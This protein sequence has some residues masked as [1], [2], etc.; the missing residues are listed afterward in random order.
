MSARR[1]ELS[2]KD[3]LVLVADAWG[4]PGDR[5]VLL[6]HGGGQTRH[7]WGGTA[8]RLAKAGWYAVALDLRGHGDSAWDPNADYG[9]D[10]Y[11]ADTLEVL[12]QLGG[13]PVVVGASLGGLA[14]LRAQGRTEGEVFSALVLVDVTPRL[15]RE[16]T[17]NIIRFMA[18]RMEEGFA[19]L[20]EVADS[21]AEYLPHRRRP[22]NLEGLKKNLRLDEDGRYRWHWDPAFITSRR[23]VS[24][25]S[26]ESLLTATARLRVPT[27]LVRGRMSDIV[28]EETAREFLDL[29]PHAE[30]VDV[31]GA[32]HMVAGDRNDI[33]CDAVV[34]F[35][36]KLERN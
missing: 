13:T 29:V 2:T 27:L 5:V 11:A 23:R 33:F 17:D 4:D 12:R 21:I 28:T 8:E 20:D 6:Q 24:P 31:S 15:N 32:G 36:S 34:D 7:A 22:S 9:L 3:D 14:A 16:G 35:L 18:A 10:A 1:I 26:A 30:Y 25:D 19:T